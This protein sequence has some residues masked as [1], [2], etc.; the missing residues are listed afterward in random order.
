[1]N[2]IVVISTPF[3]RME[4]KVK[5]TLNELMKLHWKDSY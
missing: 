1:M 5:L 4:K 3:T 2:K